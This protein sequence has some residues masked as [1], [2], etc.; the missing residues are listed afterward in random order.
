MPVSEGPRFRSAVPVDSGPG[1]SARGV[2][3]LSQVTR[4]CVRSHAVLTSCPGQFAPGLDLPQCRPAVPDD[5]RPGPR[6]HGFDPLSQPLGPVPSAHGVDQQSWENWACAGGHTVS[7]SCPGR[8]VL[9]SECLRGPPAV[10]GDS[11]QCPSARGVHQQSRATRSRVQG[12][13]GSARYPGLLALVL[14]GLWCPP[15][16]PGDSGP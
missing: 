6:A 8:I 14:D 11:G 9:V 13:A 1:P 16:V 2:D 4:A 5:S 15:A 10:P 7:T 3:L 12:P